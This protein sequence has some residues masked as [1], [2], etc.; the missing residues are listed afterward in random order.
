[1]VMKFKQPPGNVRK[2]L[3]GLGVFAIATSFVYF[4]LHRLGYLPPVAD[5]WDVLCFNGCSD[6]DFTTITARSYMNYPASKED[7][8]SNS[9]SKL[10]QDFRRFL[11]PSCRIEPVCLRLLVELVEP[12]HPQSSRRVPSPGCELVAT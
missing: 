5:L 9:P 1:M 4:P 6:E 12:R 3:I 10:T 7:G 8:V 11:C 2:S